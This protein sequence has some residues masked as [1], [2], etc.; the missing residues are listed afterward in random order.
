[1][2][3]EFDEDGIDFDWGEDEDY[4]SEEVD[5]DKGIQDFLSGLDGYIDAEDTDDEEDEDGDQG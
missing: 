3:E 4:E 5:L 2:M 1:M